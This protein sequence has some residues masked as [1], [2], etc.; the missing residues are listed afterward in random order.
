MGIYEYKKIITYLLINRRYK[1]Y[2]IQSLY[3]YYWLLN[4]SLNIL[5][6]IK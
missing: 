2:S 1:Y 3:I 6:G 5:K 4:Y